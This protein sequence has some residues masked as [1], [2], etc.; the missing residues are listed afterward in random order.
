MLKDIIAAVRD[1]LATVAPVHDG[2]RHISGNDAPP[3]YVWVRKRISPAGGPSAIGGNPR[4]LGDDLHHGEIH[5]WGLDEDDCERLRQV[6]ATVLRHVLRGRN[7]ELGDAEITEQDYATYGAV[8][9]MDIRVRLPLLHATLPVSPTLPAHAPAISDRRAT[10]VKP[11]EVAFDPDGAVA[12]DGALEA[13]E[14]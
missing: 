8:L 6:F 1:E 4:S 10:T 2:A 13:D 9:V 3:R 11:D 12:G 5:C 7:Y 14:G